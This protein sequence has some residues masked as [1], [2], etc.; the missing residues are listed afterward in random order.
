MTFMK[1]AVKKPHRIILVNIS[2]FDDKVVIELGMKDLNQ[3]LNSNI[4]SHP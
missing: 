1:D 3:F 2:I 4:L